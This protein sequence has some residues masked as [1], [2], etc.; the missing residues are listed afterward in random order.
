MVY[1]IEDEYLFGR[2]ILVA[3]VVAEG[4]KHRKVYIPD[5]VWVDYWTKDVIKK[6]GWL[7]Y[8]T[9]LDVLPLFVKK[10]VAIQTSEGEVKF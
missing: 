1:H 4:V 3:P 5:G 7:S 6:S 2:S 8:S 9:P 10:G